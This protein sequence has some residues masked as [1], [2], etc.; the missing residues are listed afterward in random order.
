LDEEN[1]VFSVLRSQAYEV[2]MILY[3]NHPH[4]MTARHIQHNFML[5]NTTLRARIGYYLHKLMEH[6]LITRKI[7][8]D[9][10]YEYKYL[11]T[12]RGINLL[13]TLTNGIREYNRNNPEPL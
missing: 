6:H 9:T 12:D 7:S 10:N 1:T 8:T 11:L 2:M 4:N 5:Q 3:D 13:H